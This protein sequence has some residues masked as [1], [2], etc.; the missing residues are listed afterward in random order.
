[1]EDNLA[2][3][4][5]E[6]LRQIKVW[7]EIASDRFTQE[8]KQACVKAHKERLARDRKRKN[9]EAWVEKDDLDM[10]GSRLLAEIKN[11]KSEYFWN[12]RFYP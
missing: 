9:W 11:Y 2:E 8:E 4:A 5:A 7:S 3:E 1:M 12:T 6:R 10:D